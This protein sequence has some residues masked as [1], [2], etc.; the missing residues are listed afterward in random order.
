MNKSV[1][2]KIEKKDKNK[3]I[4]MFEYSVLGYLKGKRLHNQIH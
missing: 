3:S 2:L 4:L 1:A